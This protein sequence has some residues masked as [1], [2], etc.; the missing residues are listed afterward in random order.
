[1]LFI[2]VRAD[3]GPLGNVILDA[4]SSLCTAPA[5]AEGLILPLQKGRVLEA[6]SPV[7][8]LAISVSTTF[9]LTVQY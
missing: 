9:N 1:M 6:V 8:I 7:N 3:Y 5:R 2:Y 4:Q